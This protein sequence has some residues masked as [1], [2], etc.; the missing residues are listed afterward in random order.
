MVPALP[1]LSPALAPGTKGDDGPRWPRD[2][3]PGPPAAPLCPTS[4]PLSLWV[5]PLKPLLT[6]SPLLLSC[7]CL[8]TAHPHP[9]PSHLFPASLLLWLDF[10]TS[11]VPPDPPPRKMPHLPCVWAHSPAQLTQMW[12]DRVGSEGG[13]SLT[14][15]AA[16]TAGGGGRVWTHWF[17]T[18]P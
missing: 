8:W 17:L 12:H 9:A 7:P 4:R 16:G 15:A 18:G 6:S 11:P 10:G 14:R 1:V 3:L 13:D 2:R 5:A